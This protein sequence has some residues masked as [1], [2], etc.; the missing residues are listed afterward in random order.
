MIVIMTAILGVFYTFLISG[1]AYTIFPNK[2]A[3]SLIIKGNKII[4]SELI[5]QQFTS[6]KYFHGRPSAVDYNTMPSGASNLSAISQ[7]LKES[8]IANK[9]A[10]ISKNSLNSS[11]AVPAEMIF[12]SASGID[13]HISLDAAKLQVNRIA[14]ARNMD[15]NKIN[16]IIN[17]VKEDRQFGILG[18][19]RVNVLLL[20]I[21]LDK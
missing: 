20:N 15:K 5:G 4:G 12:S 10:F 8:S 14:S 6:D 3:G 18:E 21:E 19:E 11:A 2:A 7:K 13:P 9:N 1:I 17:K 16:E